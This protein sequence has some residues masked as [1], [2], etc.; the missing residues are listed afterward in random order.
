MSVSAKPA[1]VDPV[2]KARYAKV[3]IA[4]K[5]LG[6]DDATYRALLARLFKGRTS[7]TQLTIG[8]LDE[9]IGYFKAQ[10]YVAPKKVAA[11]RAGDRPLADGR[12]ARK[13]RALWITLHQR[14]VV[15]D[16]S[17]SALAAWVGRTTGIA[18]LQWL[19]VE[20]AAKAIEGLKAMAARA[21]IEA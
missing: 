1:G 9:L 17:E 15:R 5:S 14:G 18:A 3:Q 20:S 6:L 7:S 12:Q 21:G 16:P 10:G 19:D 8:Q 2:R 11:R 13:L 4:R